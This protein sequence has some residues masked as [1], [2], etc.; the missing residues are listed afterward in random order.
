MLL[1]RPRLYERTPSLFWNDPYISTQMLKAHLDPSTDN[2]SRKPEFIDRSVAWMSTMFPKGA[3]ILDIGCGPGLY[4]QRLTA[5]GFKVTGMD[6]SAGSLAYAREHDPH[7]TYIL[8]DYLTL[9]YCETFD[10]VTL[11]W[12]DYGA[13]IPEERSNLLRR[14]HK[15]LKPGGLFLLDAF[16]PLFY[17]EIEESFTW[18]LHP[19][20]GF[21]S[22]KPY[23]SLEAEYF[24]GSSIGV[25]RIVVIEEQ[26]TRCYNIWNTCFSK[27]SLL[28]EIQPAGFTSLIFFSDVTGRPFE[29]SAETLCGILQKV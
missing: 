2:A 17:D 6:F 7:G 20:G 21:W 24:Y 26:E 22:P 8:Q 9:D 16:T 10:I 4:T 5:R 13:L 23:I 19:E 14:I 29:E 12:C 27:E 11:I 28:A 18:E 25:G 1:Q 15:A 3:S